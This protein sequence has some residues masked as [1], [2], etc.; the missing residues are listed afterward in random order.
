MIIIAPRPVRAG[1][2][3]NVL[4]LQ[5]RDPSQEPG[6]SRIVEPGTAA[7]HSWTAVTLS[8][9]ILAPA[10]GGIVSVLGPARHHGA[11]IISSRGL[12]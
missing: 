8:L 12:P 10:K 1:I 11:A 3:C 9:A 2:P 4:A 7:N 6:H 5:H